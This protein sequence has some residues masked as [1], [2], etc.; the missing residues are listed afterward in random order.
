MN[1]FKNILNIFKIWPL[2]KML[3]LACGSNEISHFC[4]II[5][6]FKYKKRLEN[7]QTTKLKTVKNTIRIK[8]CYDTCFTLK[9]NKKKQDIIR[10]EHT[11]NRHD[12]RQP[13]PFLLP[14]FYHILRRCFFP[15]C[16]TH[17]V[18]YFY[19]YHVFYKICYIKVFK[20]LFCLKDLYLR[21]LF[22]YI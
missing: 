22:T 9:K 7:W 18:S 13:V 6:C 3:L 4:Q 2:R 12:T 11:C 14:V 1:I 5:P 15:K 8:I 20:S 17:V 16:K 21:Y 19:S 10:C